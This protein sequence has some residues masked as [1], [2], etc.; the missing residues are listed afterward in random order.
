M[1]DEISLLN[2]V[3][4]AAIALLGFVLSLYSAR[5]AHKEK[6]EELQNQIENE[7]NAMLA[8]AAEQAQQILHQQE[9]LR[10]L[11]E[12]VE[13]E[14]LRVE[15]ELEQIR[16]A[17]LTPEEQ[18]DITVAALPARSD[19]DHM[20]GWKYRSPYIVGSPISDPK[21]YYRSKAQVREFFNRVLGPQLNC[22]AIMGAR[23]SGKTSFIKLLCNPRIRQEYLTAAENQSLVLVN[24]NLQ[25]GITNAAQF[26]RYIVLKTGEATL[27]HGDPGETHFNVQSSIS[28]EYMTSFFNRI[29][30]KGWKYILFLD[31]FEK[32]GQD[33]SFDITFFNLLRSI[34]YDSDGKIAW[35]TSSYRHPSTI[36]PEHGSQPGSPFFGLFNQYIT[37][38][39]L[40]PEEARSLI[41]EPAEEAEQPLNYKKE[42]IDYLIGLA[43]LMPLPL[44]AAASVFYNHSIDGRR[45]DARNEIKNEFSRDMDSFYYRHYWERFEPKE[46]SVLKKIANAG[47]VDGSDN[48]VIR[49]LLDYGFLIGTDPDEQGEFT[50]LEI[51]GSVFCDWV[52]SR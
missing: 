41:R 20:E 46:R 6:R 18:A 42:E 48:A 28:A 24:L 47:R 4:T 35:V 15:A 9:Q 52:R 8:K 34:S 50:R 13:H 11:G 17:N 44:Q 7:K 38:G 5:L 19:E 25:S 16:K 39:S 21:R 1:S 10:L 45:K 12:Q 23:R 30:Q 36:Q 2:V 32:L 22:L 40:S 43:G 27:Q 33:P 49:S 14:H 37:M 31:E 51:S 29:Q 3:V 26:Y